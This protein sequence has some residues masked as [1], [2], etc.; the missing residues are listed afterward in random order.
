M[1]ACECL[2][3]CTS[4][5]ILSMCFSVSGAILSWVCLPR[6]QNDPS[7]AV[8]SLR[9]L[10]H[11][12]ECDLVSLAFLQHVGCPNAPAA[13]IACGEAWQP[14]RNVNRLVFQCTAKVTVQGAGN[15]GEGGRAMKR[16]EVACWKQRFT[17]SLYTHSA[18]ARTFFS[19]TVCTGCCANWCVFFQ[20]NG[21]FCCVKWCCFVALLHHLVPARIPY[22]SQEKTCFLE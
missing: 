11:V 9:Q 17:H 8:A 16:S 12:A 7:T 20:K 6:F 13:S 14:R 18:V 15:H 10:F 19:A 5:C 4:L 2:S 1:T 22:K 3:R 21:R